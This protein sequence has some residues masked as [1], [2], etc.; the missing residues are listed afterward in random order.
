MQFNV[1]DVLRIAEEVE[2]KAA[3]F[4]LRAAVRL[5]DLERRTIYYRLAGW[6]A[7]RERAWARTRREYSERTGEFGTFDPDNYVLS[8]PQVMAGL[9]CFAAPSPS[10]GGPVGHESPRQIVHDA[11][12]RSQDTIVYYEGLKGFALGPESERMI[13][14]M[15]AEEDR[16]IRLLSRSLEKMEEPA[17][18]APSQ[19]DAS[20]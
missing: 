4:Y 19:I 2:H 13:D 11:I 3:Q 6:R 14:R 9:T 12:R 1:F 16:Y 8:N 7:R 17:T 10:Q 18:E 20:A 15:I 5:P